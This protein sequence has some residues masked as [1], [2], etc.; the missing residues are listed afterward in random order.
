M[1]IVR[2]EQNLRNYSAHL[3]PQNSGSTE[4]A[5]AASVGA[6]IYRIFSYF[7]AECA[8]VNKQ[9]DERGKNVAEITKNVL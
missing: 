8:E 7:Q 4:E 1:Y 3:R 9:I 2:N 6:S 5:G